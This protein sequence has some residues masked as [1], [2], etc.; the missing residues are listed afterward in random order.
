[1]TFS[2][3]VTAFRF[4]S[5]G[6]FLEEGSLLFLSVFL[7]GANQCFRLI[8]LPKITR[9]FIHQTKKCSEAWLGRLF[10]GV[11]GPQVESYF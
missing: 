4:P 9:E 3:K 11:L 5:E 10:D 1:V 7:D 6:N 2:K 8:L